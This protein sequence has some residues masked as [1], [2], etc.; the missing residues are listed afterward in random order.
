MASSKKY[1]S[2]DLVT[3][4][5]L[6]G[7]VPEAVGVFTDDDLLRFANE[8]IDENLGALILST[9]EEFYLTYQDVTLT[10]NQTEISLPYRAFGSKVRIIKPINS[11]GQ[12]GIPLVPVPIDIEFDYRDNYYADSSR[13]FYL[14][15]DKI[16]LLGRPGSLGATTLRIYYYLRPNNIVSTDRVST[17]ESIDTVTNTVTVDTVPSNIDSTVLVDVIQSLPNHKTVTFDQTVNV[18]SLT[19]EIT[20]SSIPEDMVVGDYICVAGETPTPQIPVDVLPILEQS[21]VCKV[22][23]SIGD[24]EGL[25]NAYA[26]LT[27]LEERLFKIIDNRIEAPSRVIVQTKSLLKAKRK[28][29]Y[30]NF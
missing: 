10:T 15:N 8:E 19:N 2:S 27:K 7:S 22:L 14:R 6:R 1:V 3:S 9:R 17:I 4:V 12:E 16:V 24:T 18:N 26:R 11:S 21:V 29:R 5:K 30:S 28:G 20:F 23:E 25:K 13:G